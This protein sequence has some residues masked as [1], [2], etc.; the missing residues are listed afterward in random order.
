[1]I[2]SHRLQM[3]F[4]QDR[5]STADREQRQRTEQ[6]HKL[7][8][9]RHAACFLGHA[10]IRLSGARMARVTRSG[11]RS[12]PFRTKLATK[13]ITGSSPFK[14]FWPVL[15]TMASVSATAAADAP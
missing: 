15:M 6:H 7:K 8:I 12:K 9:R 2:H 13:S 11:H 14:H 3:H 1:M 5:I 4:R 10:Q